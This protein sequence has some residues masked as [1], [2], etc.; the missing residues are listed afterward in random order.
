MARV[1]RVRY[2]S[3]CRGNPGWRSYREKGFAL[4]MSGT[5]VMI[6]IGKAEWL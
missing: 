3:L 6:C 1:P 2:A 4:P 5:R